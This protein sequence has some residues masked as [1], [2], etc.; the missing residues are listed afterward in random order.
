MN[1]TLVPPGA[2]RREPRRVLVGAHDSGW[3]GGDQRDRRLLRQAAARALARRAEPGGRHRGTSGGKRSAG[4]SGASGAG[5]SSG[6]AG[7]SGGTSGGAGT[8]GRRR[9]S[10]AGNPDPG[11]LKDGEVK[12]SDAALSVVSYGGYLN[13]ESHQQ[14]G[15][16][17]FK[18]YQYTAFWNTARHVVLA[19]R[20]L[21]DGRG[22]ASSSPTTRTPKSDAHNTIARRGPG[23]QHAH[24]AFDHHDS[25]LTIENRRADSSA[26]RTALRGPPQAF[27]PPQRPGG[28]HHDPVAQLPALRDGPF[29]GQGCS[30]ACGSARAAAATSCSGSTARPAHGGRAWAIRGRHE[31]R[32]QRYLHGLATHAG[33]QPLH[34]AWCC[35]R[36]ERPRPTTILPTPTAATT[37]RPGRTTRRHRSA[38]SNSALRRDGPGLDRSP[39]LGDRAEPRPH[40]SRAP[41][42]STPRSRITYFSHLADAQAERQQFRQRSRQRASTSTRARA[43]RYLEALCARVTRRRQPARATSRSPRLRTCTP[44]LPRSPHRGRLRQGRVRGVIE[45]DRRHRLRSLLLRSADRRVALARR[46]QAH[47]RLSREGVE[48]SLRARLHRRK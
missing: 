9:H 28:E 16:L 4:T 31:R 8:G 21:P 20:K 15:I 1:E 18:G 43:R 35:A 36:A 24:L 44:S 29:R 27:G 34:V 47:R 30:S 23:W 41:W 19:R 48:R 38:T 13:G 2:D 3:L 46:R 26:I 17:T 11:A 12:L 10:G 6:T 37:E 7:T 45:V 40:Q 39:R 32:H 5:G 25:P 14:E 22:R 42:R 33:R